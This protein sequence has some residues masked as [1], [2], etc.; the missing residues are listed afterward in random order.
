MPEDL[1]PKD[2]L[3]DH[4]YANVF[5]WG[6]VALMMGV[7]IYFKDEIRQGNH[8]FEERQKVFLKKQKEKRQQ[9]KKI[10]EQNRLKN[11]M[12]EW[13]RIRN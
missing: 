13:G 10:S 5:L 6:W 9:N 12:N 7:S 1:P 4:I 8:K 11:T 2:T 3:K